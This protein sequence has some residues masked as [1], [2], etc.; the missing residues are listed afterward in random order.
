[1]SRVVHTWTL[2]PVVSVGPTDAGPADGSKPLKEDFRRL[3]PRAFSASWSP[4]CGQLLAHTSPAL[5]C[6]AP[7]PMMAPQPLNPKAQTCLSW[8]KQFPMCV[9]SHD[10]KVT[11]TAYDFGPFTF[12]LSESPFIHSFIHSKASSHMLRTFI[13]QMAW[14][15]CSLS[16]LKGSPAVIV[17]LNFSRG[18]WNLMTLFCLVWNLSSCGSI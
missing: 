6:D 5:V 12:D 4:P 13:P 14:A 18:L 15:L 17:S 16:C 1:M 11:N 7:C 9:L 10:A 8:Q 3:C 2:I